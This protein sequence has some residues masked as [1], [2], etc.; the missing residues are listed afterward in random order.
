MKKPPGLIYGVDDVP[1]LAV[2][3]LSGLQH[4]GLIS[5]FLLFPLLVCREAGLSSDRL[6]DV[7]SL[8]MIA[9]AVGA[10]LPA[11]RAARAAIH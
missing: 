9:M 5:I 2:T 6:G 3:V 11:L 1:P 7:L 8:S 10:V 4:V